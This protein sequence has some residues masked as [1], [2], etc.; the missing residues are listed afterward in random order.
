VRS[1]L[2]LRD[3]ERSTSTCRPSSGGDSLSGQEH[4]SPFME[5]KVSLPYTQKRALGS[6]RPYCVSLVDST[7]HTELVVVSF[8]LSSLI[9]A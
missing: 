6:H 1:A 2:F 5:L 7:L 4:Y 3:S 8:E 9:C